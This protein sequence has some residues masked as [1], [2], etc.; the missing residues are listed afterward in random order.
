MRPQLLAS[1]VVRR[2]CTLIAALLLL[3]A[4]TTGRSEELSPVK[5]LEPDGVDDMVNRYEEAN[6]Q[7][8]SV[9]AVVTCELFVPFCYQAYRSAGRRAFPLYMLS[10]I[11]WLS[12]ACWV[13]TAIILGAQPQF[14]EGGD[15]SIV[16]ASLAAVDFGLGILDATL[17]G[18]G[19]AEHNRDII[20]PNKKT[21][22]AGAEWGPSFGSQPAPL[23]QLQARP[24][25]FS[26]GFS[27]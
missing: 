8:Q 14:N 24:L 21:P 22:L 10:G 11:R 2:A 4:S 20:W 5:D 16:T 27:F 6:A 23:V 7:E 18:L 26:A 9:A 12:R 15:L 13:T 17:A 19:V 25:V 3:M 1:G